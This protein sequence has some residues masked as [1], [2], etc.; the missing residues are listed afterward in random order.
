VVNWS[1]GSDVS[2]WS[3]SFWQVG[4]SDDL[5]TVMWVGNVFH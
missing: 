3:W 5:E 4:G 2:D 1:D